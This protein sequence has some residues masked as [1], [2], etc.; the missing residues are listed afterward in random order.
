[1]I[2]MNIYDMYICNM[3]IFYIICVYYIYISLAFDIFLFF[4][5]SFKKNSH[6]KTA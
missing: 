4:L 6:S 2:Y 3:Y 5:N 1:M